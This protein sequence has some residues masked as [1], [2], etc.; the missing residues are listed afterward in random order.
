VDIMS[1]ARGC[2]FNCAFCETKKMW[3]NTCRT[4]S[5]DRVVEEINYLIDKYNTKGIYFINDNFTIRKNE[6]VEMCKLIRKNKL[7]I[8]W[9]CDTRVDLISRELLKEMKMAGCKTIWF[10]VE[11]GS[12]CIRRKLNLGVTLE[13]TA[14]AFKLC[15]KEGI[16]IAC[17]FLL[18]TPGETVDDMQATFKFARKLDPDWCRFNIFIAVPGSVLYEEVMEKGL[19]DRV[20]D[21]ATYV[22]TEDF[23]YESLLEVQRQFH[24][25]FNKSPKRI[26]RKIRREGLFGVVKTAIKYSS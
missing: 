5:P 8:E 25:S 13:Q 21:F 17:S 3:G 24:T 20:E 22:K 1:I 7:D 14:H 23:N 15:R 16:Q 18:G 9:V 10:G 11:S 4:F 2:P 6:T 26:L 12:P 19:Y